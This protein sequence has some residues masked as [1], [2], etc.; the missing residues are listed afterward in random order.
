M[1]HDHF[2]LVKQLKKAGRVWAS[3]ET[4]SGATG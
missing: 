3:F 2:K 1:A 4:D